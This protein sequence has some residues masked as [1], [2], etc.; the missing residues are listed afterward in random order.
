M[1]V[2]GVNGGSAIIANFEKAQGEFNAQ[3]TVIKP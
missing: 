1:A 3:R 2:Q